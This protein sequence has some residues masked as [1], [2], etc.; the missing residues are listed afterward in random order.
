[1]GAI[2][3]VLG[4]LLQVGSVLGTVASVVQPFVQDN[5][6]RKQQKQTDALQLKIAQDNAALQK[7]QNRAATEQADSARRAALKRAMARQRANFG[8]QGVGS[9][10][11]SS[12]AVLLGMFQ[13]SDEE[14][15]NREKLDTL[16]TQALDQSLG[17]QQQ[18]NL[19]QQTQL[20]EKQYVDYLSRF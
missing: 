15:A 7:E 20:R 11:G 13:E 18:L 5:V 19:L 14:R 6:D 16:R 3:P 9:N 1:M 10:A 8:A 4:T 12:E 2:T 17:S